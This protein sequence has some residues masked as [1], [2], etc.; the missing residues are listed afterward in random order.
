[1]DGLELLSGMQKDPQLEGL[2][3]AM[4]TSRG[5]LTDTARWLIN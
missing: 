3:I 5:G 1:M 4:L 2:P